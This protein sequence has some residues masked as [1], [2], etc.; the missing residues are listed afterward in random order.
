[1]LLCESDQSVLLCQA[2]HTGGAALF[3]GPFFP[4]DWCCHGRL[5]T[6]SEDLLF[7]SL[8]IL[9]MIS[10]AIAFG[11]MTWPTVLHTGWLF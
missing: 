9:G 2:W 7:A 5:E 3:M 6:A 8:A 11:Q 4:G 10:T 1:M